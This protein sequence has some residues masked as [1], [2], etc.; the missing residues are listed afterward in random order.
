M[1]RSKFKKITF[2]RKFLLGH[3]VYIHFDCAHSLVVRSS[4]SPNFLPLSP[5]DADANDEGLVPFL[6]GVILVQITRWHNS[7]TDKTLTSRRFAG[8][9][10]RK[11]KQRIVP[12]ATTINANV[13]SIG[14][15]NGIAGGCVPGMAGSR[16]FAATGQRMLQRGKQKGLQRGGAEQWVLVGICCN[17]PSH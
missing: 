1:H 17:E 16:L 3:G 7:A 4:P 15:V 11:K 14:A 5:N 13:P 2:R 10:G 8:I 9:I 12:A 6:R